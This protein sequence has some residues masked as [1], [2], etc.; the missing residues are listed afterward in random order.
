MN[1]HTKVYSESQVTERKE[2][3]RSQPMMGDDVVT[4][5]T[6]AAI[7]AS[8]ATFAAAWLVF[9]LGFAD[10]IGGGERVVIAIMFGLFFGS[11]AF[12]RVQRERLESYD[13]RLWS[14]NETILERQAENATPNA[15]PVRNFIQGGNTSILMPQEPRPGALIDFC[16]KLAGGGTFSE[17]TAIDF[18]YGRER[19]IELRDYMI[20]NAWVVWNNPDEPRQG[21]ALT[22]AGKDVVRSIANSPRPDGA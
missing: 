22:P 19:F 14:I 18:G 10:V 9:R 11:L 20:R 7:A 3:S 6:L 13:D 12:I 8:V 4:P 16:A 15:A 1:T 2:F 21:M 17:R 5:S